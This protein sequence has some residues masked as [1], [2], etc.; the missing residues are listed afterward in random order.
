MP[1]LR[2]RI[3]ALEKALARQQ[4]LELVPQFIFFSIPGMPKEPDPRPPQFLD[5]R[6]QR[7]GMGRY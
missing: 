7:Q 1:N 5:P 3:E 6:Y 2:K 4:S